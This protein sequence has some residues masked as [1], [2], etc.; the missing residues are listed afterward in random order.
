MITAAVAPFSDGP[1]KFEG[2]TGENS[3]RFSNGTGGEKSVASGLPSTDVF[4][5]GLN[6][7][8]LHNHGFHFFMWTDI[9]SATERNTLKKVVIYCFFFHFSKLYSFYAHFLA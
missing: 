8:L 3:L 9:F 6:A 2:R 7:G 4:C 1:P 5:V